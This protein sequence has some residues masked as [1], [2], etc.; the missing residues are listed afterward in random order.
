MIE[1]QPTAANNTGP[2]QPVNGHRPEMSNTAEDT[3]SL[4]TLE[5]MEER[6][7]LAIDAANI[8]MYD[9]DFISNKV[10]C[11]PR[12]LEIVGLTKPVLTL[13][14][15]GEALHPD[16]R[17]LREEAHRR[18]LTTGLIAYEARVVWPDGSIRWIQARG[19][20]FFNDRQEPLRILGTATDITERKLLTVQLEKEVQQR[21]RELQ[22]SND[23]L[24]KS[25]GELEQF[26]YVAS[27]DLQEPLR[28]IQTFINRLLESKESTLSHRDQDLCRRIQSASGRMNQLIVDLLSYSTVNT[29]SRLFANTH[30]NKLLKNVEE[31]LKEVIEQAGA[32]IV[33]SPMPAVHIIPFQFEQLLTNLISN[34]IKFAR[35]ELPP[36]ITIV[37]DTVSGDNIPVSAA[38]PALSY[39]RITVADNGIGFNQQYADRIFQVFQRLHGKHEYPGTGIGLAICK[40]IVENHNGFITAS[41]IE[42]Q[43][44]VFIIY[45]PQ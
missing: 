5:E 17:H 38:A 30:L 36:R 8:G 21:T 37:A 25:N 7:R 16:D 35:A 2:A 14:E 28:K 13:D 11:S 19:K 43:G 29:S 31:Q 26:A 39:H 22:Q 20:L 40:K 15:L 3:V 23:A 32:V 45:I 41:G 27:H 44:A 12:L 34:S 33:A 9:K 18:A 42:N 24:L 6:M 4:K 1:K 10:I